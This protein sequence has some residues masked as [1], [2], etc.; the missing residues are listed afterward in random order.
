[1]KN[2]KR[3]LTLILAL[4]LVL[5]LFACG[6]DGEC[7]KHEDKDEDGLCDKCD[8]CLEHEDDDEDGLCDYCDECLE[9]VDDDEDGLCDYCDEEMEE[10]KPSGE[11]IALIADDEILFGLVLG[12]DVGSAKMVIDEYVDILEE[13]G[14]ELSVVDDKEGNEEADV[15]ILIGTV[16]SRGEDYEYDRYSLGSEGYA[17]TAIDETKIVVTGGSETSLGDAITKFFEDVLGIDDKA[18]E[19]YE[20]VFTEESE[21][22]EIQ[23]NYRITGITIDGNDLKGYELVR[24]KSVNEYKDGIERLQNF[25]YTKAGYW[26]P[27]VEPSKAGDKTISFVSVGKK[28]AGTNGFRVRVDDGNLL[29]ECAYNN[30]F[31]KAFDEY[32]NASFTSKQGEIELGDFTG[33]TNIS[34][35]TY[36][37]FGAV[38]DGKTD[39]IDAIRQAHNEANK[40]G[41]TVI[42]TKGKTYYVTFTY[43]NPIQVRTN[44]D[45]KG[46][47]FIFDSSAITYDNAGDVFEI[48][49]TVADANVFIDTKDP[50]IQELNK[51]A[52]NGEPVIKGIQHGDEQTTKLDLGLGYAAM[53]TVIDSNSRTYIRWGYVDSKGGEQKEVIIVDKDGNIDPSTPFLLDYE[54]ITGIRIHKIEVEEITVQNAT[55][56]EPASRINLLGAYHSYTHGI[57]VSRP[58]VVIKNITHVIT[59]EILPNAPVKVDKDGLS[60]DVS[61]EGF[62][63]SGGKILKDGKP[64]SGNDVQ[65]F[66]GPSFGFLQISNTHNV[67]VE[68]SVFQGR[69]HYVEGTYDLG[70]NTANQIVFKNCKQ[71]NFFDTRP[72]Y[73]KFG[74]ST[75]PN[76]GLCWGIMG[77]NYTK[78]VHY[79]DSDLTRFDAHA[80]VLNASVT[81][82]KLGVVRLIGGGTFTLDGVTI[83]RSHHGTQPIQLREDYGATFNGTLIMKNV[84]IK[85][86]KYSADGTYG[87]LPGIIWAAV[88]PSY[89]GYVTHFPNLIIDNIEIETTSTE[90]PILSTNATDTYSSTNHWPSRCPIKDDVSNPNALFT[91][92]YETK[93]PNIVTED[94]SRF[95]YLKGFKKVDKAPDKLSN[96]EYT[97]VDNGNGTYTVIAK[98]VKNVNPYQPP[99]F[100]EILNMKGKK[101][102][103]GKA[104]SLTI[105]NCNFFKNVEIRD[106][107]GVLKKVNAPK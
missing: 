65:P 107:D 22:I 34:V 101:N 61:D 93:N 31:S 88:S 69:V 84:T 18:D 39:D 82:G 70:A 77:S 25:F 30:L 86:G 7:K 63:Y 20:T 90:V 16:T 92:Y 72:A 14:Y 10:G 48:S 91:T 100:I 8:E 38:G 83:Y 59:G 75:F 78:N 55:I 21:E 46:A 36:E 12:S 19:I 1:M 24:D 54:K 99:E 17:I 29:I 45:W 35:I 64:Y 52:E 6:G 106:E 71:S 56:T 11:G 68:D 73:T 94:P 57:L 104:L 44:V 81:G 41:Q 23:D 32:Y 79:V 62:S 49:Q 76:L 97:V 26:L 85:D 15:E 43:D 2:L 4:A 9:H 98:G 74:E 95:E 27:I 3:I 37:D 87:A 40:G 103:D 53:L 33:E 51:P 60:Y 89:H 105:Y 67:L 102:T 5:T 50:R 13:L 42:G 28:D 96:G 47:K 66:T 58:N 80:G